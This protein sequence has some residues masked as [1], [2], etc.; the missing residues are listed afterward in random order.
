MTSLVTSTYLAAHDAAL[1]LSGAVDEVPDPEDVRPGWIALGS[2]LLLAFV[3]VL[4]WLSM[5]KQLR[6]IDFDEDGEPP[7]DADRAEPED[8]AAD[9]PDGTEVEAENGDQRA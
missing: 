2:F 8:G 7:A 9:E 5:R 4:L 3:T 1:F 6:R